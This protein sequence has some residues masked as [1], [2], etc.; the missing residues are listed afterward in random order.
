[1]DCLVAVA[2]LN[3]YILGIAGIYHTLRC[4]TKL[5]SSKKDVDAQAGDAHVKRSA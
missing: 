4:G 2:P 1:M 3:K 5:Q